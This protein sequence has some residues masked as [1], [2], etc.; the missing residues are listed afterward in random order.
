MEVFF[1]FFFYLA[2]T[3]L[4]GPDGDEDAAADAEDARQFAEDA[5]AAVARRQV[6]QH[7]HRQRRVEA[8][9]AVRQPQRVA[10]QHLSQYSRIRLHRGSR[11]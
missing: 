6:V 5:D 8:L 4:F 10:D 7:G 3:L 1:G 11:S 2:V 9:V